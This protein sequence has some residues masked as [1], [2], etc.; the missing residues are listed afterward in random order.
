MLTRGGKNQNMSYSTSSNSKCFPPAIARYFCLTLD[1]S[2][3]NKS[4]LLGDSV[5]FIFGNDIR[6]EAT[7]GLSDLLFNSKY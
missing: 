6:L 2:I 4:V 7:W 3:L 5:T 1:N